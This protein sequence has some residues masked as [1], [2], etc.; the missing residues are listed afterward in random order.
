MAVRDYREMYINT[1]LTLSRNK[2]EHKIS[3]S[4]LSDLSFEELKELAEKLQN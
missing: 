4:Y 1:I 2:S 3:R